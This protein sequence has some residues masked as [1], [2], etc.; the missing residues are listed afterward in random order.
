MKYEIHNFIEDLDLKEGETY[1][2]VCPSC[3]S[4][5]TFTAKKDMGAVIYNC[6][7]L[8]CEL[9]PSV[10]YK[11]MT[12][13]EIQNYIRHKESNSTSKKKE[14]APLVLPEYLIG[15]LSHPLVKSFVTRW[16]LMRDN[17][18]RYDVKDRRAVIFMWHDGK[19]VDAIGRALDGAQPKWL[20][21]GKSTQPYTYCMGVATGRCVVVE[22]VISAITIAELFPG[23]TGVAL[24]GTNLTEDHLKVLQEYH[25]I[26]VALDPDAA[27]KSL[28]MKRSIELWTGVKTYALSLLDD[29]K[30]QLEADIKKIRSALHG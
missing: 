16:P 14:A 17:V 1:R 30:Y 20:R 23:T 2:G 10:C 27:L 25:T 13:A 18:R 29:P 22:D 3:G 5:N 28:E 24:L 8:S 15:D 9:V 12:A 26:V 7:K 4:P 11:G 21:Y 6:Y 19:L